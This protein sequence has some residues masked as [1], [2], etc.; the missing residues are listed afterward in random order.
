MLSALRAARDRLQQPGAEDGPPPRGGSEA[1]SIFSTGTSEAGK[2]RIETLKE[3]VANCEAFLL[4]E[5]SQGQ[6]FAL[7]KKLEILERIVGS[8]VNQMEKSQ[9]RLQLAPGEVEEVDGWLSRGHKC[10]TEIIQREYKCSPV[11]PSTQGNFNLST[12][13]KLKFKDIIP[14]RFGK[15][16]RDYLSWKV[17]TKG[18]ISSIKMD[19]ELAAIWLLEQCLESTI[20]IDLKKDLH[21]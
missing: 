5:E 14:A 10:T 13:T 15:N 12:A 21:W 1:K 7:L 19:G 17:Q 9:G 8:T 18:F 3:T 16:P 2:A 20:S 6:D 4:T 11:S